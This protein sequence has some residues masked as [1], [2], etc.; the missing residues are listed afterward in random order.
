[1]A[2]VAH[3]FER[4]L[5]THHHPDGRV[6]RNRARERHDR[7]RE[8]GEGHRGQQHAPPHQDQ[9]GGSIYRSYDFEPITV[10][11]TLRRG[12]SITFESGP[13]ANG[14]VLTKQYIFNSD[15]GSKEG[16]SASSEWVVCNGL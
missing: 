16:A 9:E 14:Y 3:K 12:R 4:L 13:A 5:Q 8:L 2:H 1:V 15:V 10:D 6:G 11:R 7:R